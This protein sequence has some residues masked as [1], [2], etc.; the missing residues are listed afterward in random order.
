[1]DSIDVMDRLASLLNEARDAGYYIHQDDNCDYYIGTH[2]VGMLA[3]VRWNRSGQWVG[4]V[5]DPP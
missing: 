1:M 3:T 2:D 4:R 5:V